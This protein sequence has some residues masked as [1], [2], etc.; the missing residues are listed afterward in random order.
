MIRKIASVL[1]L[2]VVLVLLATIASGAGPWGYKF[3]TKGLLDVTLDFEKD[4]Q[5][6]NIKA[7]SAP[8]LARA[9]TENYLP[10]VPDARSDVASAWADGDTTIT[11]APGDW[12]FIDC[13][14]RH[15]RHLTLITPNYYSTYDSN[16][17][18]A[19]VEVW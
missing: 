12:G 14:G 11:I 17:T 9:R 13:Q 3:I 1:L 5:Q 19:T 15:I 8:L 2:L 4:P 10:A 18:A 7:W 6:I 16:A